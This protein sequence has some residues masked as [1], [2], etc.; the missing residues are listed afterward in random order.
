MAQKSDAPKFYYQP[1]TKVNKNIKKA[2]FIS[3]EPK[4]TKGKINPITWVIA[5]SISSFGGYKL[6]IIKGLI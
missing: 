6:L 5:S 3:P 2:D 4:A 1:P